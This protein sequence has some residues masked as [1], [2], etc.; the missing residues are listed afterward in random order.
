MAKYLSVIIDLSHQEQMLLVLR[1]VVMNTEEINVTD[2]FI[3]FIPVQDQS[4]KGL[5][6]SFLA[7]RN[8]FGL[9]I[10]NCRDQ[11]YNIGANT[12]ISVW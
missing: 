3:Y 11:G 8:E 12:D 6:D 10:S 1:Y 7:A 2:N 4:G 5:S 9:H